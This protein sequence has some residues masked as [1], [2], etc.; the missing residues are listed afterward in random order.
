MK[1]QQT[2][3]EL[4]PREIAHRLYA[5]KSEIIRTSSPVFM[6]RI[7]EVSV[8]MTYHRPI[9]EGRYRH[10]AL[11]SHEKGLSKEFLIRCVGNEEEK[12]NEGDIEYINHFVFF[13]I[14]GQ[15]GQFI[16]KWLHEVYQKNAED[17]RKAKDS[18]AA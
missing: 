16:R 9:A 6:S 4:N 18:K 2:C 13:G 3:P 12:N 17:D 5:D 10:I 8:A 11:K 14:S 1:C 15:D 7:S